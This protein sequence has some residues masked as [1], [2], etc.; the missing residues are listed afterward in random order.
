MDL[1]AEPMV[2]SVPKVEKSRYYSVMLCDGN[3]YNYG[4]IGSRATGNEAGDYLVVGTDWKGDAPSG[5]KKVFRSSTQFSLAA[6]RTQ[7][8][9]PEDMPNVTKIQAA[10]KVQPLSQYLSQPAPPAAP[11]VS[12]PK[13]NEEMVKTGFFDYLGFALQFAPASPEEKE[14]RAKLARLGIGTGKKFDFKDLSP[15]QQAQVGLGAE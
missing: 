14:I 4:Y 15:E 6:Y 1:R 3:T 10:Y 8:F 11:A 12:F 7:L 5:I 2:L 13:I 9:N